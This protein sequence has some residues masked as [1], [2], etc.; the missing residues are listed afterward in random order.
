MADS[1]ILQNILNPP[2]LFFFLGMGVIIFKSDL[3]IPEAL[4]KFFSMYLLFAIGF[5]GGHEL[6]KTPFTSEHALTLIAC[7]AMATL[8]PIYAYY[9][10]KIKLEKHNAAALAGS[11]GSISAVTFVT[12]GAYLHNLNIEYGGFIVAGMAL[13]E[14]PAIVIA[15]ILDRLSKNKANGGGAINWKALLH[16]A[17]FGSSIYLLVGALIVGYL[18]G[19][20]GWNAE[21]PFTEDLFK[22]F[23]TFFLLDMGI[24]AAKRFKELT[25]VGY[26]LIGATLVLMVIN[27]GLGLL[28]T[29]LIHMPQGDAVM[30]VVLCA[31]ASYIAV[32]AAMKDMIPE[33]NPSIYLTVALSIV[34]PIN[35]IF[36][37]PLYHYLVTII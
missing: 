18:T 17:L 3:V 23:L 22:G 14:S 26:F 20:S 13:M 32:P 8:V 9:I 11:F 2:V 29:K 37:I 10:L 31:S 25:H 7:S 1:A 5:K 19:D 16:E 35:I 36:G 30:F 33:A 28:L 24:S 12:A 6:Y 34:F 15:V 27:A 21:K 4:S